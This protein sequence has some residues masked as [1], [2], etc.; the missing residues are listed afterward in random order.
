MLNRSQGREGDRNCIPKHPLGSCQCLH[1]DKIT[2]IE[3]IQAD[4][5]D[6][7]IPIEGHL[8]IYGFTQG[9]LAGC[10]P[11]CHSNENSLRRSLRLA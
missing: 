5:F 11:S 9:G 7:E 3:A 2:F 4:G 6:F 10:R 1:K 8:P